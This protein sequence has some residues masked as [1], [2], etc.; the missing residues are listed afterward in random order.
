MVIEQ[1]PCLAQHR[2]WMTQTW[3]QQYILVLPG[4][5]E[6]MDDTHMTAAVH[7][8]VACTQTKGRPKEISF[9][10]TV[11]LTYRKLF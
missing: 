1:R 2:L 11:E 9:L 6:T 3:L 7:T 8:C 10:K 4:T 5:T